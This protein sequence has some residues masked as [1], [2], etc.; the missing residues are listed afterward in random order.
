MLYRSIYSS[1]LGRIL[2][3]FH[4]ESLFGLYF[5]GQK[6]FNDLIKYEEVK[7]FDDGKNIEIKDK[8]LRCESLGHDKNKVSG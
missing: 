5:E 1:P 8:N 6:E 4:E 7:N 2:I 3:L